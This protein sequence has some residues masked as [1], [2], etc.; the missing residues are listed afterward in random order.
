MSI[1]AKKQPLRKIPATVITG[2]LGSGKTSLIQHLISTANGLQLAFIINEFGDL[3]VD[4]E[5]LLGCGIEN[6]SE[7]DIVELANGCIC[8]TVADDFLPTMQL[9][10]DKPNPPD[11]IIIETSGLALPKPLLKA[12]SWPEVSTRATVDGV[13]AVIDSM[14]VAR[15]L[16]ANNPIAVQ[17]Q[18]EADGSLDHESPLEELFEEQLQ[19]A[20]IIIYNKAEL[21]PEGAWDQIESQVAKHQRSKVKS[22]RASYGRIDASILLGLGLEAEF[23]LE[24]RPSHHE[25]SD[26]HDHEDFDS[27]IIDLKG[28]QLEEAF[29]A[30]LSAAIDQYDILR[31]K[32]FVSIENKPMR[33]AI[34]AVGTRIDTYFDKYWPQNSERYS[35]LVVIGTKKL[36]KKSVMDILAS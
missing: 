20:D 25:T 11:H 21:V 5:L 9:L 24:T 14:A 23:D 26:D 32:G 2:F 35:K 18:R 31:V 6:C 28:D 16:F 10:L 17:A 36:N 27:F 29:L 1:I 4:K 19:S 22:L 13:I 30:K 3:G 34:Q 15:G 8:C 7:G 33:L 12:F